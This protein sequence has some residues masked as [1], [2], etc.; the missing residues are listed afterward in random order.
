MLAHARPPMNARSSLPSLLMTALLLASLAPL[1]SVAAVPTEASEFYYGV[2]YD[3]SSVDTDLENFTGLDIPE[4]LGE[5]MGAADD[6]GFNLIIGQLQTGSSN[7]YVHHTEDITPQ[8]IQ[9]NDGNDVSVWSRTDDVT[10]RHGIL[11]D[12]ILQTDWS[13]TTFGSEPTS[14]DI[15]VL[16]SLEQVLTVDMTYTEYL[17][18][19]SNLIGADMEFSMDVSAAVGLNIDALFE[20][21]GDNFP[22]D[23]DAEL[24]IGYSITDS[25][26]QWRLGSPDPVYVEISSSDNYYWDCGEE[27]CGDLT[28]DYTGAVDYSFSVEGI[29]TEDFGLDA[30]EFDLEVSD[31]L[32]DSGNFDMEVFGEWDFSKGDTF[33]VDLGDG[34][35]MTTSV[36]SCESCPPGNPLM[37]MM[38]GYVLAGSGEA[39]AEQIGEDLGEG[40]TD[41]IE[42]WFGMSE[43]NT[44]GDF[45]MYSF[46]TEE[47]TNDGSADDAL[48]YLTMSQGTNDINWATVEVRVSVDGDMPVTCGAPGTTGNMCTL[49]EYGD[50]SD[51]VWS[52]GDGV[53]IMDDGDLCPSGGWCYIEITIMDNYEG[54]VLAY[55]S[56]Y[57]EG[58][59]PEGST[60]QLTGDM[61]S[62]GGTMTVQ[63]SLVG[64]TPM[65]ETGDWA[66]FTCNDGTTIDWMQVNDGA[67]SCMDGEDEANSDGSEKLF[68]CNDGSTIDWSWVNDYTADCTTA[69][70]EGVQHHYTLQMT[71]YDESGAPLASSEKT[72]CERGC[73]GNQEWTSYWSEDTGVSAPSTYG[74]TTMCMTAMLSET[75]ASS[76][77][78][79]LDMM[80]DSF[81]VGPSIQW[82]DFWSDG[83]E[84]H[85]GVNVGDWEEN[86]GA[87]MTA[88]LFDPSLNVI[89]TDTMAIDG[90]S[91]YYTL[92]ESTSVLE[93]GEYC[94]TVE[95][96]ADGESTPYLSETS[97]EMVEAHD[98][99]GDVSE[100]VE[101]VFSAIAESGLEDVLEQF[102]MNLEDRLETVEPFEEFPYNDGRWAPLW[103]NEHAA[104]VGVG[105]YVM[106]DDGAYTMAGPDTQGYMDDAP[107]KLSIR[108]LT[109]VAANTATNGMEEATTIED[110]VDVEN[111]DLDDIAEDLAEAG[112]DV[113][114]LNL[115]ENDG[116]EGTNNDEN[117]TP[118]T[119]A[120][121][122]E[123]AGLLP[124]LSPISMIAVIALAGVV[125]GSRREDEE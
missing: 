104:M 88:T 42:D 6:A 54:H 43:G 79:E 118:P 35:G 31:S 13:E 28:G 96:L 39:F 47:A 50:T 20:G 119:A 84:V 27:D 83:L 80:C 5:V 115:P 106:N 37:F 4:I 125:A 62:W 77:L 56:V 74:E 21:G 95:L 107:A 98:G 1:S 112:V 102:G 45:S 29:P 52:V 76:P 69:E 49:V 34:E 114:D 66:E 68:T 99:A 22:V 93:E 59:S 75:G 86:G 113:S 91:E 24:T 110:I 48:A 116:S 82:T 72:I 105:V 100:R 65:E 60:G 64:G 7:V 46:D 78:L 120:E 111:H 70:D 18:D 36:Q 8:T 55:T 87:T 73:D 92:D 32:T 44:D 10:L 2:E 16:Q 17:D 9:D 108:Y 30:G 51:Q 122:A 57:V 15:D 63:T 12:S 90:S 23:F 94:F 19:S 11:A 67:S 61:H 109:G 25:T 117:P 40:I 53:T 41:G 71:L 89:S 58:Y 103:S 124:F 3:W 97:C 38:M 123:D 121:A 33:T 85:T 26:S 81:W 101:T 14:F